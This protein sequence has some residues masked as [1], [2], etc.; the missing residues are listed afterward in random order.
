MFT[1]RQLAKMAGVTPRTLR[2][3]DSIGLLKPSRIGANG[4]R[5]Y[6]EPAF[7]RLQQIMFYRELDMPL[8]DIKKMMG[9]R[10]FDVILA[11]EG[12]GE[13]LRRESARLE[14]LMRTVDNTIS[15]LKGKTE[16][17]VKQL[18]RGFTKE[19]EQRYTEEAMTLYDPATVK[20]SSKKWKAYTQ[21]EKERIGA[22][23]KAIYTDLLAALPKGAASPEVQSVIARWHQHLQYFWNPNDDQLLG[24]ADLYNDDPRFRKNFDEVSSRLAPFMREAV[25]LYVGKRKRAAKGQA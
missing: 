8:D 11:L 10:D 4:Y 18:F 9:R 7:L 1:V 25:K 20:D 22:E 12:H 19:E 16:M 6:D 15:H 13:A 3:Y 5:Y 17:S 24:L 23:G 14:R 2:H 21:Q